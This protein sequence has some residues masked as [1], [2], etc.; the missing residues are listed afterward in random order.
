MPEVVETWTARGLVDQFVR[1]HQQ[2]ENRRFAFVLGAGASRS[3]GIPTAKELALRWLHELQARLDTEQPNGD[4]ATWATAE[5]LKI[6]GF[7]LERCAEHYP[8][9]YRLRFQADPEEGYA[10]LE[11]V[12]AGREPS[13][14]YSVLAQIL[15]TTRHRVV[16]TTNFDNLV[17]DAMAIYTDRAPF[18]CGHEALADFVR[19][20]MRHPVVAKV[21]RDLLLD[22]INTPDGVGHL[23]SAW[24]T[25]MDSLLRNYSPIVI[26]YGGNDGSLMGFFETLGT[27]GLAR[28][29]WCYR[30]ADGVPG[31]RVRNVVARHKGVLVPIAGFDELMLQLNEALGLAPVDGR[32]ISRALQRASQYTDTVGKLRRGLEAQPINADE[33]TALGDVL[34]A[35]RAFDGRGSWWSVD[36]Q[37]PPE[38]SSMDA[39]FR[40][41]LAQHPS[42]SRLMARYAKF[43]GRSGGVAEAAKALFE[44]AV[45]ISPSDAYLLSEYAAFIQTR[46]DDPKLAEKM[47]R[48]A[49]NMKPDDL[50][51]TE[52]LANHLF[53][54]GADRHEA[55]PLFR[56]IMDS[57]MAPGNA[58]SNLTAL[59]IAR[60]EWFEALTVA[61]RAL[62]LL[63]RSPS[64]PRA[65]VLM[66]KG[67]LHA[68][69]HR[70]DAVVLPELKAIFLVAPA[71]QRVIW[72]YDRVLSAARVVLPEEYMSFY[73]DVA[74][75]ILD[76][77]N[78]APMMC[79]PHWAA[80]PALKQSELPAGV[81]CPVNVALD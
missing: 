20:Q 47:L 67:I 17:S 6:D 38:S 32:L 24:R 70:S 69:V 45:Q 23:A 11:N 54:H 31:E 48:S 63:P 13:F 14:G 49:R 60:A 39:E 66:Y 61:D 72:Y 59:L 30:A 8:D 18:V 56:S 3:S 57:Y 65:E 53:A 40:R 68:I 9:I 33:G 58:A 44:R 34:E 76:P 26:G 7:Q 28:M 73:Q 15:A 41:Q 81:E 52:R 27:D 77:R 79:H 78:V 74:R 22:P 42:D 46:L 16:L 5:R 80:A 12:I 1:V 43:I 71:F 10:Q 19:P 35:M 36:V 51:L 62:Q 37:P 29:Y 21:H 64:Q 75:A 50:T 4:L 2:M 55:E 25:A